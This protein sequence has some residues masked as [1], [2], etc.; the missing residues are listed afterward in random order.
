[1]LKF[2]MY[3]C[4]PFLKRA[5]MMKRWDL[6]WDL[7]SF[8]FFGLIGTVWMKN[9]AFPSSHE[10]SVWTLCASDLKSIP[11]YTSWEEW[12]VYLRTL[13]LFA[14]LRFNRKRALRAR[15]PNFMSTCI[16][17]TYSGKS[18]SL[19]FHIDLRKMPRGQTRKLRHVKLP[20]SFHLH[21][22]KLQYLQRE[23]ET[24]ILESLL[25]TSIFLAVIF[26]SLL[27]CIYTLRRL[28]RRILLQ[29]ICCLYKYICNLVC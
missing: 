20:R 13:T 25:H 23:R 11:A 18:F 16:V 4:C 14:S 2:F 26:L 15:E 22:R 21:A 6:I 19:E 9:F 8:F 7:N 29:E 27:Q 3:T 12:S 17:V 5:R 10:W 1:M 24:E 28:R